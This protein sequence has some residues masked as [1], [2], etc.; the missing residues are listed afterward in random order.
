MDTTTPETMSQPTDT[1]PTPAMP[2]PPATRYPPDVTPDT[3][4]QPRD[5]DGSMD[6]DPAMD[7]ESVRRRLEG[8]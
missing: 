8:S 1:D 6:A 3:M 4:S 2:S 7:A 5:T